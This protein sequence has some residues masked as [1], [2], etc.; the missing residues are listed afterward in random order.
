MA[1]LTTARR[2]KLPKSEF[3]LPQHNGYPVDT[4]NR[5]RNALTRVAQF[6]SPAEQSQVRA[7]VARDYPGIKQAKGPQ[8]KKTGNGNG[9]GKTAKGRDSRLS[10]ELTRRLDARDKR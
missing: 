8:A 2:N 4:A 6:G 3:A 9:N 10:G 1:A 7:K 5:A